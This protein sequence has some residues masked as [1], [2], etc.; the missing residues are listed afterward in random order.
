M[1][2]LNNDFI[3][4]TEFWST[5]FFLFWF[6]QIFF[7][8]CL[9]SLGSFQEYSPYT[10]IVQLL[11]TTSPPPYFKPR[12][13]LTRVTVV[14]LCLTRRRFCLISNRVRRLELACFPS[15]E[16]T[17]T[18]FACFFSHSKHMKFRLIVDSEFPVGT[19]VSSCFPLAVS[20]AMNRW[21][22]QGLPSVIWP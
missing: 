15:S 6:V 4:Y 9:N 20:P 13:S 2:S 18:R 17:P 19:N 1:I 21:P 11:W 14:Q 12:V 7:Y 3:K 8:P 10:T 22:L 16:W 5:F